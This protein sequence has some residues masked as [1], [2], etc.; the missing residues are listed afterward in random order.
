LENFSLIDDLL[1]MTPHK[2]KSTFLL[3]TIGTLYVA[4]FPANEP[5]ETSDS[6]SR[7]AEKWRALSAGSSA[8]Q[9]NGA[10]LNDKAGD[11]DNMHFARATPGEGPRPGEEA[12]PMFNFTTTEAPSTVVT[13]VRPVT[14]IIPGTTLQT[15]AVPAPSSSAPPSGTQQQQQ[16]Q[17]PPPPSSPSES[18]PP[19][20]TQQQQQQQQNPIVVVP[21][22]VP[23]MGSGPVGNNNGLGSLEGL[24]QQVTGNRGRNETPIVV[25][26]MPNVPSG[27]SLRDIPPMNE[28][29]MKDQEQEFASRSLREMEPMDMG[30]NY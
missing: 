22:P 12:P 10:R 24:V 8:S 16:Q 11:V 1:S 2:V 18:A 21:G 23:P 13:E 15:T 14:V 3:L 26:V 25:L 27:P 6:L 4:G 17:A 7:D 5:L 20:G 29:P 19:S 28:F 30:M 9:P